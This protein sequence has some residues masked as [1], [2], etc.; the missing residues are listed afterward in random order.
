MRILLH[1]RAVMAN[2]AIKIQL[3]LSF[4]HQYDKRTA[5]YNCRDRAPF[6]KMWNRAA[7]SL[8]NPGGAEGNVIG[9]HRQ[10]HQRLLIN[11]DNERR[12]FSVSLKQQILITNSL[13]SSSSTVAISETRLKFIRRIFVHWSQPVMPEQ[14]FWMKENQGANKVNWFPVITLYNLVQLRKILFWQCFTLQNCFLLAIQFLFG[15][16]C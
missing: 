3:Q 13:K 1:C 2:C 12:S 14:C 15:L 5:V 11:Q 9:P 8:E 10:Q 6:N 4:R 16:S 7:W